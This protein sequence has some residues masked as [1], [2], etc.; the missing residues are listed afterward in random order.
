MTPFT[1]NSVLVATNSATQILIEAIKQSLFPFLNRMGFTGPASSVEKIKGRK[2]HS[3]D[4]RKQNGD[5]K[6][7]VIEI[8]VKTFD[9]PTFE[10]Y[11]G[12]VPEYGVK[13]L[14]PDEVV[15]SEHV[16]ASMLEIRNF[17]QAKPVK[18]YAPFRPSLFALW[19]NKKRAIESTVG[20]AAQCL[21][22][23]I[24]FIEHETSSPRVWSV[25]NRA[26]SAK[27]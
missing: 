19:A 15:P 26:S 5:G 25:R 20:E 4:F 8:N 13:L 21:P 2:M 7:R 6:W 10:I 17:L 18:R 16:T 14:C 3:F 24:D 23:L 1:S 22:Q 12:V 9:R 11:G 27:P